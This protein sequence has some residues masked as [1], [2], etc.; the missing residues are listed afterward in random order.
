MSPAYITGL[1]LITPLGRGVEETWRALLAGEFIRDHARIGESHLRDTGFQAVRTPANS[2]RVSF[3]GA[4]AAHQAIQ[5]SGWTGQTLDDPG[6]CLVVGTSKGPIESWIDANAESSARAKGPCHGWGLS[7]LAADIACEIGLGS[8]YRTTLSAACAS[9]LHALIHAAMLLRTGGARRAI[10]VAA[11]ASVHPLFLGSFNRLGVL[12]REGAGCRPFDINRTG[13]L[14]SEAAAAVCLETDESNRILAAVD[15]FALG[16]DATHLTGGDPQG[17]TMRRLLSDAI[18]D[19][20]VDLVHAHATG[21][22]LHDPIELAAIESVTSTGPAIYSHKGAL[23]HS[24]GAAGLVS[25][26]LSC[27]AHR[28]GIVPPNIQT[29][30]PLKTPLPINQK[31]I[32]KPIRRSVA[33]A[34]GFGGAM[35][36]VSLVSGGR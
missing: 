8:G 20:P 35:A 11:E 4:N 23:G 12:A 29:Q 34:A 18:A 19:R 27:M 9:G 22:E 3:L 32:E 2:S 28:H 21:T 6:T 25:I 24:L 5:Q 15:R 1:G 31:M 30:I 36:A 17:K 16:A 13:F 10:V 14:M 26:V 33:L 7:E